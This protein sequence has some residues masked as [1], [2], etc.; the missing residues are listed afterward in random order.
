MRKDLAISTFSEQRVSMCVSV[1]GR[2]M[3]V[4]LMDKLAVWIDVV[5]W[6]LPHSLFIQWR[7]IVRSIVLILLYS[8]KFPKSIIEYWQNQKKIIQ[9]GK[10]KEMRIT[11][12]DW[13]ICYA[14]F[15]WWCRTWLEWWHSKVIFY[16]DFIYTC[17]NSCV[18]G[19]IYNAFCCCFFF[20][21]IEI[22][23]FLILFNS[24]NTSDH[25]ISGYDYFRL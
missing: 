17:D 9:L 19:S 14:S 6:Q 10:A 15:P 5:N 1:H 24:I 7:P 18:V 13:I 22:Q 16:F 4:P 2:A 12:M 20:L 8:G 25:A 3:L 21:V 23:P 11:W